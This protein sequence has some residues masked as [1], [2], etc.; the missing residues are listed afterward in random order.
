[1]EGDLDFWL[2]SWTCTWDGGSGTNRV[3]REFGER[4]IVERFEAISPEPFRGMSVS[5]FDPHSGW[6]QTWVDA[7]GSY[8]HFL[9]G[10]A[11]DGFVF[12]TS[13]PVDTEQVYKRMVFSDIA[14]DRFHWRWEASPDGAAWT[15]RWSIDYR[16]TE[17]AAD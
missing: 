4:V 11:D 14:D 9:G 6:R 5:V 2:G 17:P 1:M 7:N 10:V 13:G 8:W 16:R 15:A 12:A 3:T